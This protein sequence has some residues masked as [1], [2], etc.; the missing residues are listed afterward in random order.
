MMDDHVN[1]PR[2]TAPIIISL[3][4]AHDAHSSWHLTSNQNRRQAITLSPTERIETT[5][6]NDLNKLTPSAKPNRRDSAK[7]TSRG[8][9]SA[10]DAAPY[11]SRT[12]H[13]PRA[14]GGE[15][16]PQRWRGQ[17][18]HHY[19]RTRERVYLYHCYYGQWW[20]QPQLLWGQHHCGE[21]LIDREKLSCGTDSG[22]PTTLWDT[23]GLRETRKLGG[24]SVGDWVGH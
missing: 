18:F 15:S 11:W 6:P 8:P 3:H 1:T 19:E 4:R 7:R 21:T 9:P 2:L 17:R 14:C 22:S 10:E 24:A 13:F 12:K 20:R 5:S 16:L 23:C